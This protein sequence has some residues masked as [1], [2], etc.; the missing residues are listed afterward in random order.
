MSI[1]DDRSQNPHSRGVLCG[2][3]LNHGLYGL[4]DYTDKQPMGKDN[5]DRLSLQRSDMSIEDDRSQNP[6]SRGVQCGGRLNHGLYR[7][8]DY[9]DKQPM[10]KD[11]LPCPALQ[12]SDMSIEGDRSQNPHSRGAQC[13]GCLNHGLYG[14]NDYTDKQPMGKDNLPCLS[15]QRSDMSI[16]D[17]M[18]IDRRLGNLLAPEGRHVYSRAASP[19]HPSPRGATCL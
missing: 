8:N 14:L 15:L 10:G 5:W 19:F 16:E 4:S 12:R 9:T 18:F 2:G 6:H 1:E 3:C 11:N 13:G 17:D 7:L